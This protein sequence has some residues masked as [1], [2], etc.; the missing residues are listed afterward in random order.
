MLP[1]GRGSGCRCEGAHLPVGSVEDVFAGLEVRSFLLTARSESLLIGD[2]LVV[3]SLTTNVGAG[4]AMHLW[5]L[6]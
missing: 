6:R 3:P 1:G 5:S 2:W 4:Q